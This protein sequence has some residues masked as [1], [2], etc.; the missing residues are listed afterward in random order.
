MLS[1]NEPFVNQIME[2]SFKVCFALNV[3]A[4][5]HFLLAE[6]IGITEI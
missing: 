1:L 4:S 6:T 5:L 3:H 2:S